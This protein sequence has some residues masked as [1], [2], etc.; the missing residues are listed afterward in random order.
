MLV[1]AGWDGRVQV[2]HE[3]SK[4]QQY[5]RVV[6]PKKDSHVGQIACSALI[7]STEAF[8]GGD[9]YIC[10]WNLINGRLLERIPTPSPVRYLHWLPKKKKLLVGMDSDSL[11][12]YHDDGFST[13]GLGGVLSSLH[14]DGEI[15]I[16]AMGSYVKVWELE[17]SEP[18]EVSFWKAH[19]STINSMTYCKC[20]DVVVT[21]C[22]SGD[23]RLWTKQG[24]LIGDFGTGKR[25]IQND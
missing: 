9:Q 21:I 15:L 18:K 1:S 17:K 2:W 3:T 14:A 22:E 4:K 19:S 7:S 13:V 16:T 20:N 12:I 24:R 23:G 8:T 5:P 10:K 6:M 25:N 11:F